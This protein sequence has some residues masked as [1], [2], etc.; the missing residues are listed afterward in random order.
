MMAGL[1]PLYE[2]IIFSLTSGMCF[3]LQWLGTANGRY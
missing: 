2:S 1:D 3:P